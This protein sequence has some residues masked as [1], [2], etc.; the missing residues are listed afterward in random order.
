MTGLSALWLPILLSA[1][2]V[3]VMSSIIHMA[4]PWHK[5]DYPRMPNEDKAMDALRPLAI[6]PGDY[7]VPRPADMKDMKSPAFLEK[8]KKG[9][10]MVVTVMP[11]G[12]A[13]M[14]KP[15]AG[16]FIY[17][18]VIGLFSAYVAGRALPVGAPYLSVFRFAGV[19]AFVGYSAA[20]W[21]MSIWYHRSVTSTFKATVD[22]LIYALLTAGAFG[23]LWPR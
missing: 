11:N 16:W 10:V 19:T 21:Q 12:P 22:G 5:S 6:P 15:L 14:G 17:S 2:L 9:P 3:F 13:S 1:V 7:M 4:S 20:L 23:W 18:L 8:M